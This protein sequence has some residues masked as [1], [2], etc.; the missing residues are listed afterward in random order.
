MD[1]E[2]LKIVVMNYEVIAK[3][4]GALS[5]LYEAFPELNNLEV[6]RV[7]PMSLDEW[8]VEFD[9]VIHNIKEQY[10]I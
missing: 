2:L 6:S 8:A 7:V 5:L 3:A 10:Q 4:V 1:R 9:Q